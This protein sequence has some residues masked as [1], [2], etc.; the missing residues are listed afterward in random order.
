MTRRIIITGGA[1]YVGQILRSGLTAHG[2]EVDVFDRLAG[3]CVNLTR[4]RFLGT[5]RGAVG[6][7]L[8]REIHDLQHRAEPALR[9]LG[10]IRPSWDDIL[11]VRSHLSDRFRASDAV[12]HLAGI[13]HPYAPRTVEDDFRR[14]N[15]DGST[16]VFEAA[17]DAG[18]RKFIFASSMQ[19]YRINDPWQ[20]TQFPIVE[21]NPCP[22]PADGQ[23]AYG[24]L[25]LEV[26]RYLSRASAAGGSTQAVALRLEYPGFQ[27]TTSDNLY[28]STSIE[29]L[30]A[31]FRA[32][33]ETELDHGFE[34]FNLCDGQVA[35]DVVDIQ[36]FLRERWPDVPNYAV[37]NGSVL[38]TE[39]ARTLLGYRPMA[40]GTYYNADV[41]W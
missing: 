22:S 29:N 23:T 12:I 1:G 3:P 16:N 10:G 11:D 24:F 8:A 18:V 37:A 31:G 19:V 21:T 38:S 20:I 15:Y 13:P 40:G 9:K 26:E 39:K 4:R 36:R 35:P 30:V 17:R 25:K 32:A 28:V 5:A 41:I 34:T 6:R 14:I 27:S 2:Y 33:L 7:C